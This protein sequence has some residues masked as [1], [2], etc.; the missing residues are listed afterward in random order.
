[1]NTR[2]FAA[3]LAL[4]ATTLIV[5][6]CGTTSGGQAAVA[7]APPTVTVV[8]TTTATATTTKVSRTTEV[9]TAEVTTERTVIATQNGR[10]TTMAAPPAAPADFTAFTNTDFAVKWDPERA[11]LQSLCDGLSEAVTNC[12]SVKVWNGVACTTGLTVD[13]EVYDGNVD[14]AASSD[15]SIGDDFGVSLDQDIP[16][17]SVTDVLIFTELIPPSGQANA[18]ITDTACG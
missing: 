2:A 1:M 10:V 14:D 3:A 15:V 13:V 4:A 18:L 9:Q 11:D 6:A 5:A 8:A 7:V 12:W 16:A 17:G